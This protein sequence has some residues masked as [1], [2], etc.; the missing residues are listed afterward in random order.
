MNSLGNRSAKGSGKSK[1]RL[2]LAWVLIVICLLMAT[3]AGMLSGCTTFGGK[4]T[5]ERLQRAQA[6]GNFRDGRFFNTIPQTPAKSAL[7]WDYLVEQFS[8]DQVRLPPGPVPVVALRPSD[9]NGPV[10]PGLRFAWLG[11][12]SVYLEIDGARLLVDPVFSEYAAP[13][14]GLGPK[15]F[16]PPPIALADLPPI[17]AVMIS[18]DHYDHLDMPTIQH[19][20]K[21]GARFFVPLGVGAHLERWGVGESQ[22]VELEWGQARTVG[23]VQ[24]ICTPSRHY[25]GRQIFDQKAT[26]WSSW[27]MVGPQNRVYYSGDTGFSDHFEKTGR[28]LGPF[29]LSIIKVGSYGPGA[30]WFDIHMFPEDAVRAHQALRADQMLPVHWATFNMA[31]HAWDEP[32]IRTL[33]AAGKRGVSVLTPRIGQMIDP[34]QTF[35]PDAWWESVK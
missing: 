30:S 29:D 9:I 24:I 15:R 34:H 18:H 27:A 3:S 13:F 28:R 25:S 21:E 19:L 12:A 22:I 35:E 10:P 4:V 33:A 7:Y 16:H 5:G 11:H 6:T 31:F 23:A 32:I 20:A 26:F 17:D 1:L 2:G 8:G 14:A